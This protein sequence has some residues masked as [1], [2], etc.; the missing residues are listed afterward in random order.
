MVILAIQ[1]TL[2]TTTAHLS[3]IS[4]LRPSLERCAYYRN[5]MS[6]DTLRGINLWMSTLSGV[7]HLINAS[8]DFWSLK[9]ESNTSEMERWFLYAEG[10]FTYIINGSTK[11][12]SAPHSLLTMSLLQCRK[13]KISSAQITPEFNWGTM[14]QLIPSVKEVQYP[15]WRKIQVTARSSHYLSLYLWD[16]FGWEKEKRQILVKFLTNTWNFPQGTFNFAVC[17]TLQRDIIF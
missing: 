17:L 13:W 4:M 8:G 6:F 7:I 14:P 2:P 9:S 10:L 11:I 3:S 12:Q 5:R 15:E 1:K 16:Y